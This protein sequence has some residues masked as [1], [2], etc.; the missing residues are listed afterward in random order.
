[1]QQALT[2]DA[3]VNHLFERVSSNMQSLLGYGSAEAAALIAEYY[4]C[5]TDKAH[6]DALGVSV[7]D[8]DY[9]FHEAPLGMA[10]RI[11]YYLGLKADPSPSAYLA[12]RKDF[13]AQM[14]GTERGSTD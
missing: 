4:K 11:H 1:M 7:Q 5:F 3:E 9:F 14:K 10:L 13:V 12:W 6:C 2:T 8:D